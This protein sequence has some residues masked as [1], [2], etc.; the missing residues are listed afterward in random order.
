[1]NKRWKS[2]KRIDQFAVRSGASRQETA[3]LPA[4]GSQVISGRGSEKEFYHASH[5]QSQ[6]KAIEL[7]EK[8]YW[9]HSP[10]IGQISKNA[11]KL[12][13]DEQEKMSPAFRTCGMTDYA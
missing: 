5:P 6:Q 12:S 7:F 4:Q 2:G 10:V 3:N 1:M 9:T 11:F 8:K 13:R